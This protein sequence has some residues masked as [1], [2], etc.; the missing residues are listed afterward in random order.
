M[1]HNKL[2]GCKSQTEAKV[3]IVEIYDD[4]K[5]TAYFGDYNKGIDCFEKWYNVTGKSILILLYININNK[6]VEATI[7]CISTGNIDI[8]E[9][10]LKTTSYMYDQEFKDKDIFDLFGDSINK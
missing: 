8:T 3:K 6:W 2:Y 4:T 9:T 10:Y 7:K 5:Y 1:E